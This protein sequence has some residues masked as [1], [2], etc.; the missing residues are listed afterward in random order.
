MLVSVAPNGQYL[1]QEPS[2][3]CQLY[4]WALWLGCVPT[5]IFL[6]R[7]EDNQVIITAS[8]IQQQKAECKGQGGMAAPRGTQDSRSYLMR[9]AFTDLRTVPGM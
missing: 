5:K 2:H 4:D 8:E 3:G 9:A 6:R 1:N 7:D